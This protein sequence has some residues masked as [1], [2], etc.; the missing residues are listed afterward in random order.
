MV[1]EGSA[2]GVERLPQPNEKLYKRPFRLCKRDLSIMPATGGH[3]VSARV[4]EV[5]RAPCPKRVDNS[6]TVVTAGSHVSACRAC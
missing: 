6:C 4:R 5:P 3:S 2:Q 1:L